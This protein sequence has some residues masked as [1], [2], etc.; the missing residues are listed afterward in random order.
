MTFEYDRAAFKAAGIDLE[1][2][3]TLELKNAK[4]EDL[5]K[6]TLDPLGVTF[7]IHGRTVKLRPAAPK[8]Q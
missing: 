4:I 1:R 2:P 7:E 6:G 5:L 3:V 8:E